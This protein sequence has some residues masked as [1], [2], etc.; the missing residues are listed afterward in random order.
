MIKV[1]HL[2]KTYAINKKNE[3]HAINDISFTLPDKGMIF[4]VGKSGS[5]KSTLLNILGGLDDFEAGS[6][7]V[8]GNDLSKMKH[9]DFNKYRSSYVSFIFQDHFLI[10]ELSVKNNVMLS[11]NIISENDEE[12][13]IETLK[14]VEL[15][16]KIDA[17]PLELSGGQR[18]RV[19]VARAI[20]K[21]PKLILCDEP[22]G[23]LD[24]KTTLLI[25]DLL[26]ELSKKSL[27]VVVSHDTGNAIK[28]ADRIIEI[29]DG[30]ILSDKS[31]NAYYSDKLSIMN[32][33]ISIPNG[34]TIVDED[35]KYINKHINENTKLELSS[36]QFIDSKELH[37]EDS[38]RTIKLEKKKY[39]KKGIRKLS[40]VLI[41]R[42][43]RKMFVTSIIISLIISC[44]AIFIA[45]LSFNGNRELMRNMKRNDV[46]EVSI[47]KNYYINVDAGESLKYQY[48]LSPISDKDIDRIIKKGYKGNI[49]KI[50]NYGVS[51]SSDY[52]LRNET[53]YRQDSNLKK[54]YALESY[55]TLCCNKEYL[56]KMFGNYEVIKGNINDKGIIITDY[57]ADSLIFNNLL[58]NSYDGIVGKYKCSQ[59]DYEYVTVSAIIKTDYKEKFKK[60]MDKI[61]FS[62]KTSIDTKKQ[63]TSDE[64]NSL[65]Q[66]ILTKYGLC[67]SFSKDLID[68]VLD[69]SI[70]GWVPI[71]N[72]YF[73]YNGEEFAMPQRVGFRAD[74]KYTDYISEAGEVVANMRYFNEM[75]GTT[76]TVDNL[77]TFTP[78]TIKIKKY[79]DSTKKVND[80][81]YGELEIKIVKLINNSTSMNFYCRPEDYK[82]FKDVTF[83]NYALL[84]DDVESAFN[85]E[86][87]YKDLFYIDDTNIAAI[88]LVSKYMLIFRKISSLL[89]FVL[90]LLGLVYLVFYEVSN[91][92]STKKE[93]GILKAC[94]MAQR[95][96]SLVFIIQQIIVCALVII[97]STIFSI[98]LLRFGDY[99]MV[100]SIVKYAEVSVTGLVVVE[101]KA[102]SMFYILVIVSIIIMVSCAIPILLLTKIKPMNIIKA[103][104]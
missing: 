21:E 79:Y 27:V 77:D 13:V 32:D 62:N 12:K 67:Y 86:K 88:N 46:S 63:L 70:N 76:Y 54:F 51:Y 44:F 75:F 58:L 6:V 37:L 55:G 97:L 82:I 42:R 60:I 9:S 103:K 73:E 80:E 45:L 40:K 104:E 101:F 71:R 26:K 56:N 68:E 91:I 64:F 33:V 39:Y 49:Y 11:L 19:A 29:F 87:G 83:T 34:K 94:G 25:F 15:E 8:D 18:Q 41:F 66:E 96:I 85:A 48:R 1:E 102:L 93:I 24:D 16:D 38:K 57:M 47:R 69:P 74:S 52:N 23:N 31:K 50:Y 10:D 65:S 90:G 99:L 30:R 84:L 81:L 98:L 53:F 43:L 22:T 95:D 36:K 7:I 3:T 35:I 5:G 20:I 14:K 92:S 61:D 59:V 2:Q 100:I 28:Y 17:M 4:V 78:V 72:S 89:C